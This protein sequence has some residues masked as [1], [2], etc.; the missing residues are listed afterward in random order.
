MKLWRVWRP[1]QIVLFTYKAAG[2]YNGML[3]PLSRWKISGVL[4]YQG[5]SN[6]GNPESYNEEMKA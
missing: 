6:T 4:Y 5:E 2:L 1:C 3:S